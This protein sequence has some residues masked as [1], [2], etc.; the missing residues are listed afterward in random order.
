M[1]KL[2]LTALTD[3]GT[4]NGDPLNITI[5]AVKNNDGKGGHIIISGKVDIVQECQLSTVRT[6]TGIGMSPEELR[7]NLVILF[8]CCL[9]HVLIELHRGH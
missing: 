5:K 7:T 2:R 6:D 9:P 1:E 3:E 8:T 4:W